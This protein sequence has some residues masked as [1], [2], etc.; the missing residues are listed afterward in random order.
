MVVIVSAERPWV[1]ILEHALRE[2]GIP[3]LSA[4]SC[5]EICGWE[6]FMLKPAL[7]VVGEEVRGSSGLEALRFLRRA[8]PRVPAVF[9][10]LQNNPELERQARQL[11]LL[12]FGTEPVPEEVFVKILDTLFHNKTDL[13]LSPATLR[14]R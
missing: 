11:S 9:I 13:P 2:R 5:T 8:F 1:T 14:S 6:F 7:F 10:A 3:F 4:C 12:Y